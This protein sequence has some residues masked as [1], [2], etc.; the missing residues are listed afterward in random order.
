[1]NEPEPNKVFNELWRVIG[2][3]DPDFNDPDLHAA[4]KRYIDPNDPEYDPAIAADYKKYIVPN[5]KVILR[6]ETRKQE[7]IARH[8][9]IRAQMEKLVAANVKLPMRKNARNQLEFALQD[10]IDND[11]ANVDDLERVVVELECLLDNAPLER[12]K[13][14]G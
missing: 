9:R 6:N 5:L 8:R 7:L 12:E 13:P 10:F 14:N 3:E 2:K 11:E 1:M 4:V